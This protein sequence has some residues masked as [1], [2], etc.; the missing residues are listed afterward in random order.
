MEITPVRRDILYTWIE[1]V[2]TVNEEL[3]A[4]E[5]SVELYDKGV[6]AYPLRDSCQPRLTEM[7]KMGRVEVCGS[8]VDVFTRKRVSIYRLVKDV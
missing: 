4:R 7:C 2:L 5:I 6:V 1:K 3:T 8:K